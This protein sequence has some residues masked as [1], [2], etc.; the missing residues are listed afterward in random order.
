MHIYNRMNDDQVRNILKGYLDKTVSL[1]DILALLEMKRSR[2]FDLLKRY[3]TNPEIFSCHSIAPK[4][5]KKRVNLEA[6]S[7]LKTYLEDDKALIDNPDVPIRYYNYTATKERLEKEQ[8]F[9][10]LPTII[11]RAK[12]WGFYCEKRKSKTEHNHQVFTTAPGVLLQHDSS[13]HLFAP[14]NPLKKKWYL[15]TTLDDYS[16]LLLYGELVEQETSW[17]HIMAA[18]TVIFEYGV[19]FEWYVDQLRVF[20][21]VAKDEVIHN[22]HYIH[23]D[24]VNPQW[25]QCI[26]KTGSKVI[27]A[28]SAEAKGK[29][30]RPYRWLQDRLVRRCM[31]EKVTTIQAANQILKEE[32]TRYNQ[33]Q[34]HSTTGEIPLERFQTALSSRLSVFRPFKIE[35]PYFHEDD[36]FCFTEKRTTN[37]YRKISL[38][39]QEIQ[40]AVVPKCEEVTIHLAKVVSQPLVHVRIWWEG[41]LVFRSNMSITL[42]DKVRF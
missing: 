21:Y 28:L 18:K 10:S 29:I 23:T 12:T 5:R 4:T 15:I 42:F 37:T 22:Q 16:R 41:K 36:I 32:K 31:Q 34:V 19:P 2:F 3:R 38:Y 35:T 6:E 40:L 24:G 13:F 39:N 33:H 20:R 17:T 25:K 26:H 1:A 30:E 11:N 9:L 8:Q 7:L 14:L 27:Y